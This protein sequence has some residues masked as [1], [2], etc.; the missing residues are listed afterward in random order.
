MMPKRNIISE[1]AQE[2]IMKARGENKDI[3]IARRLTALLMHGLGMSRWLIARETG[4]SE[5]YITVLV[6]RYLREG[7]ESII[8]NNHK[9]N[10]RN[11]SFEEEAKLLDG[12][13]KQADQ[14]RVIEVSDIKAAYEENVGHT[15]GSGQIY[16]VLARHGWR[17]V[18]PRSKHPNKASDEAI[19]A[20]KKL[21][22]KS[23][24]W[25]KL[26]TIQQD[27]LA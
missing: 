25:L 16:R 26:S 13:K 12:F 4:Y 11:I 1:K 9:G 20:S 27:R 21:T 2:E 7:L 24:K 17:K 14:G 18:M 6:A 8:S 15:I 23:W 22:Q 5:Q 10:R 3:A 19:D